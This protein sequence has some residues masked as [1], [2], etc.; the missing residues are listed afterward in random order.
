MPS[1]V[2]P[3]SYKRVFMVQFDFFIISG[4]AII[5]ASLFALYFF[6]IMFYLAVEA[7][8]NGAVKLLF[9]AMLINE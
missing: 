9:K 3:P 5:G 2:K 1:K 8:L 6:F 4:V 7:W